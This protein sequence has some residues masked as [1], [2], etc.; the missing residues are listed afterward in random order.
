LIAAH[1]LRRFA[2]MKGLTITPEA[3]R[4][5]MAYEWPGN[6]RELR[7]VIQRLALFAEGP[8]RPEDLPPDVRDGQ[9]VNLLIKAC[10]RCLVD[11][12]LTYTQVIACL[13]T[14]LLR[15]ALADAQGN[16]TQAARVLG[17]SLSTLRD[18]LKKY[19]LDADA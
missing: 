5:L 12:S 17:L 4:V 3:E 7:N 8:I 18:K 2:P 16:R 13:E 1:F 19:G 11:E 15:Q 14:N 6:V 10:A 9:P